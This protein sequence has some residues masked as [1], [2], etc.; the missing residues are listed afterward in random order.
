M[1]IATAKKEYAE[2]ER[3]YKRI[4]FHKLSATEVLLANYCN[5]I[6]KGLDEELA[7]FIIKTASPYAQRN[8]DGA[9]FKLFLRK[10]SEIA[11]VVG[12][13]KAVAALNITFFDMM[14]SCKKCLL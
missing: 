10:L 13:Y 3:I 12:K 7:V 11:F 6:N 9:L 5:Y 8:N 14:E 4:Q 2:A 1:L